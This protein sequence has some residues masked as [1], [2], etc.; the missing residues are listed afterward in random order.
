MHY[1]ALLTLLFLLTGCAS[2]DLSTKPGFGYVLIG[3]GSDK[4]LP[5]TR[6]RVLFGKT[7]V[8]HTLPFGNTLAE[9][10]TYQK[11]YDTETGTVTARIF[12][13]PVGEYEIKSISTQWVYLG[14]ET[15]FKVNDAINHSFNVSE[16]EIIYI[17][18]YNANGLTNM[19]SSYFGFG[20]KKAVPGGAYYTITDKLEKD[21]SAV[22]ASNESLP[23]FPIIKLL[24]E[25]RVLGKD[26]VK[27]SPGIHP[28]LGM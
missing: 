18:N 2:V 12:Q 21:I 28:T 19:E 26:G 9:H 16:N 22:R 4:D 3:V 13:L 1:L 20:D 5:Y 27:S 10:S 24:P 6:Y 17:G 25:K 14:G 8:K 11:N 23:D 7:D 15:F